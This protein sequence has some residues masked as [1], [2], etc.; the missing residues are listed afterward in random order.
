MTE[1]IRDIINRAI[2][3][4]EALL[5]APVDRSRGDATPIFGEGA[6]FD[7]LGLVALIVQIEEMVEGELGAGITLVSE[8]AMSAHRS[9]FA[10]IGALAEFIES[11]LPEAARV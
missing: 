6:P 11:L 2:D 8:K 5:P 3:A 9:P 10:T 4:Q 7:S 1:I